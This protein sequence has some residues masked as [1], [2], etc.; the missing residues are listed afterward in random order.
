[1]SMAGDRGRHEQARH[2]QGEIHRFH[3]RDFGRMAGWPLASRATPW[4]VGMVAGRRSYLVFLSGPG[5]SLP[6]PYQPP[7]VAAPAPATQEYWYY[8]DNPQGYYPYVPQCVSGWQRVPAT[9]R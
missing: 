3:E 9:A 1:M 4:T 2:W 6:G 5:L 7:L 8:C